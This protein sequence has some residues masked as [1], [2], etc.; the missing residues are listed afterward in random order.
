M[1]SAGGN[2]TIVFDSNITKV[3]IVTTYE[4]ATATTSGSVFEGSSRGYV[5]DSEWT[6]TATLNNGYVLD[7]AVLTY[8]EDGSAVGSD[9]GYV[10]INTDGTTFS[11]IAMTYGMDQTLTFTSKQATTSTQ[12]SVDMSTLSGWANVTAGTHTLTIKAKAS[13]YA[14]SVASSGVSFT[15]GGGN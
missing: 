5:F 10:T 11:G 12:K 2:L 7:T 15:K 14:D 6:G 3:E 1:A 9:D 4:T 13:G 8:T